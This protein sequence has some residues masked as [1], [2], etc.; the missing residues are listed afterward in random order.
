[1]KTPQEIESELNS[2]PVSLFTLY[3]KNGMSVDITNFGAKI[4]RLLVPDRTGSLDDVVLGFDTLAEVMEK[5]EY[6]GAVCGRFAN[7]IKDGRFSIDGNSY[8]LAINNGTNALHGGVDAFNTK[9]WAVKTTSP[10]E[11]VLELF[12]PDGDEGYPGNL[13]IRCTYSLSDVNEFSIHYEAT[14]DKATVIGL[15]N[16]SYFNLKGAGKGTI[17]NHLLQINA[18]FYTVLDESFALTGEILPVAA[19]AFDFRT[20]VEIGTRID[21]QVFVPGWGIDNN[22]CIRK[23]Q[24]GDCSLAAILYE[25]TT[26]RKMEVL[27]TQP[28]VQIY[29]GNWIEKQIGK[30][31][32]TYD[33]QDAVCLETQGFPNSPNVAHFPSSLLRP[34]EKYDERCIYKFSVE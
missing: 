10:Q 29:T 27:T 32:K 21:H 13:T 5:E 6:F 22:W 12:S 19:T 7:R 2:I 33:R 1:M 11:L 30:A 17:K 14:T 8:S 15:T 9:V 24:M 3:N 25:P 34:G 23:E 16:H 18:D 28:G 31:G 26:G 4:I 20:P